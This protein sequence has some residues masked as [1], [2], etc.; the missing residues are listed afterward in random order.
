MYKMWVNTKDSICAICTCVENEG[1]A[2]HM[3]YKESLLT[4][5]RLQK[6]ESK[7]GFMDKQI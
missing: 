4:V 5:S 3:F 7:F 6:G 2:F 1:E